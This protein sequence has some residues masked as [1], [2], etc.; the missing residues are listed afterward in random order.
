MDDTQPHIQKYPAK[1][2]T[3]IPRMAILETI[4]TDPSDFVELCPPPPESEDVH[5]L[6]CGGT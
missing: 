2:V 6:S 3:D 4:M 5:G 1:L